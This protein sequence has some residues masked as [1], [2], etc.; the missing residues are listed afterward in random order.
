MNCVWATIAQKVYV[1]DKTNLQPIAN[2]II[3]S[4]QLKK[5]V[6][7]NSSGQADL[8]LFKLADSIMFQFLGYQTAIYSYKD[9]VSMNFK[10]GLNE[11]S[12]TLDE[13]VVSASRFEEK[14]RDVAQPIE[15]V[16]A[17]DLAFMNQ[18]SMADVIQNTGNILVQ[19]SQLG[20]GSPIIR[21][22]EANKVL[23]VID[24]IRLNNIIYRSGHLQNIIT[25]D[26]SILEK[27]EIVFGPGSVVYGS[28]ALGGVVHFYTKNPVLSDSSGMKLKSNIFTRYSTA[29]CEKTGHLDFSLGWK[30]FGSLT[31]FTFSDFG[32]LMQGNNRN[33]FYGNWGKRTFYVERINQKDSMIANNNPNLQKQSG[34]KQY[35]F[36]QKF[37]YKQNSR[38]SHLINFQYS[39]TGDIPRYDRLTTLLGTNPANSAWYY[40]PQKRLFATYSL[41]LSNA[42]RIYDDA[43]IV[44][45]YQN[46]EESRHDRKFR[47][48]TL[49]HRIEKLDIITFNAD[50]AKK[51]KKNEIHY[52]FEGLYNKLNSTASKEDIVTGTSV[53]LDT[54]YPDGGS[55]MQTFAGYITHAYEI[56]K[57]LIINDGLRVSHVKLNS[58]FEDTTFF[59]FP[60][61]EVTQKNTAINGNLGLIYMPDP[62][63]RFTI[64]GSSGFRAPNVDDVSKV[65]ESTPGSVI[66]PNPNLKPEYTYNLDLGVSKTIR[67]KTTIG[68]SLFYTLYKNAITTKPGKFNGQDSIFYDGLL[69][70]VTMNVNA[71]EANI[72]GTNL[73]FSAFVTDNFYITS[74][75]NYT[76]GRIETDTIDYPLDHIPPIFGKTSFNLNLKK[77]RGEFFVIYNG[78]KSLKDYNTYGEDNIAYATENGMPSWVTL[79]IRAAYQFSKNIQLQ[80]ALENI[81]DQNYRVFASNISAPGRNLVI[82]LRGIF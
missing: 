38:I 27:T 79:N 52:G 71:L 42:K 59:P 5:T 69:S 26:N 53:A 36:L 14:R 64:L 11:K 25:L 78:W 54:R 65:F 55:E 23:M 2:V 47:K 74:T 73:Y 58:I 75:I 68:A 30:K 7:T 28:D 61:H 70:R 39:T 20:G 21:G 43:R 24:G 48:N 1:T 44:I 49:N 56:S 3:F 63:W 66:V 29:S 80:V 34:Y 45:G 77:F 50:F 8:S 18:M 46:I 72:Y 51:I 6:L 19:K 32:D 81:L 22:F 37:I 16:R 13:V 33:P 40:G 62:G 57:K 4:N 12:H 60:F 76:Y 82:T 31:S 9:L 17:K 15:V 41:N 67:E 10:V 35:D